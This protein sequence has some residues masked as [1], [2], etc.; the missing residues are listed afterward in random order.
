MSFEIPGL[1]FGAVGI[2]TAFKGAL[3]TALL[4]ESFFDDEKAGCGYLALRYHIEK[5]HLHLWRQVC[6]IDNV[7]MCTLTNKPELLQETVLGILGE[8]TRLLEEAE[9]LGEKHGIEKASTPSM[10]QM[11]ST[12][13]SISDVIKELSTITVKPKAR[14]RWTIKGKAEFEDTVSKLAQLIKDLY[15]LTIGAS[16][17]QSI[18]GALPSMALRPISSGNLLQTLHEPRMKIDHALAL[19]ARVKLLQTELAKSPDG[20]ATVITTE[21]LRLF[22]SDF[23]VLR[24]SGVGYVSVWVEWGL[25]NEG[26][27]ADEYVRRIKALGYLLEQ[28]GDPALRLPT[29]YGVFEDLK[30]ESES[31][32]RRFGFV[33]G[34]P[35]ANSFQQSSLLTTTIRQPLPTYEGNFR[36]HPPRTLR[37]LI[38][39]QRSTPI[40]VLGDRFSLAFALATAFSHFHSSRWLHKGFH[41][42]NI[43]FVAHTTN[44]DNADAIILDVKDPLITGF[45]YSRPEGAHSLSRGP[46]EDRELEYYYHPSADNGFSRRIDLYSFG[47]V[48]CEIGRWGLVGDTVSERKRRKLVDRGS[49]RDYMLKNVLGDIGWRMGERYQRVVRTLLECR[50]PDDD[51]TD[52]GGLFEQQYFEK[53]IQPLGSCSA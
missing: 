52:D 31:G 23:G 26:A 44:N 40:P 3:D 36:D 19:S 37:N 38:Q 25:V 6:N 11:K 34:P 27:E 17:S 14:F 1:V 2:L 8:I 12:S 32:H 9:K 33:F 51:Y 16:E 50:L 22:S 7:P 5:T 45:Q 13:G 28:V 35:C 42:G 24:S 41:S 4:I 39:N 47:V 30:Y 29:C 43:V 15:S 48:L 46:L 53:V 21:Q 20:T 10:H 49:W 18:H